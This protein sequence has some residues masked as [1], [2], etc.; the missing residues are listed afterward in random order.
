MQVD[1]QTLHCQEEQIAHYCS[2][3]LIDVG[4]PPTENDHGHAPLQGAQDRY[5][6]VSFLVLPLASMVMRSDEEDP[7]QERQGNPH[8]VPVRVWE[9]HQRES[10]S[11]REIR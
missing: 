11:S 2:T 6:S 1:L 8:K 10:I 7:G 3:R 5:T 9:Q 4:Q